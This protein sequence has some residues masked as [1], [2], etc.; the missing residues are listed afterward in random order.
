MPFV[1]IAAGSGMSVPVH[2]FPPSLDEYA[3]IGSRK[4]SFDPPARFFGFAV[5]SVMYVSLCGP[6]SLETS[7]SLAPE[8]TEVVAAPPGISPVLTRYWYFSHQVGLLGSRASAGI[9]QSAAT[10]IRESLRMKIELLS[11][12]HMRKDR[13]ELAIQCSQ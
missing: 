6:H 4:I 12:A 9:A 2:V 13:A 10:R 7:T 5:L 11:R 3:R 1:P 8:A